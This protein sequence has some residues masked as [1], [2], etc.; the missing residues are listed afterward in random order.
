MKVLTKNRL[1][2]IYAL[3]LFVVIQILYSVGIL[4]NYYM[5]IIDIALIN[6]ILATSLNIINGFTG[7][8]SLG[9]GGFMAVGAYTAGVLTTLIWKVGQMQALPK[10]SLFIIAVLLGGVVAAIIGILLGIPSLR[11]RGDYLAIVT[12]AFQEIVRVGINAIDY[13][14]GP[15]GLLGIPRLSTF[16]MIYFFTLISIFIMKNIVY[17]T[18][19]RAMKSIREDEVASELVG[20][21]TT[22][23]KV[24]AFS[25]G[26][27]FAGVAGALLVHV[28][29][30]AHP[31]MFGFT[32][33]SIAG[34][35]SILVMVYIGGAG[36][37]SGSIIAAVVLT[38]L[39]ELLRLGIDSLNGL[40]IFPFTIG[41]EWR[42]VVYAVLLIVVML[43]RTEGIMGQREFKILVPEEEEKNATGSA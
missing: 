36:S 2:F 13:V 37:L 32:S 6:I 39:S 23:Y 30:L 3:I 7:Q 18:V 33:P 42:M 16:A 35:L 20:V 14:G 17:S 27:F 34:P 11:L 22:K 26:A 4:N 21:N 1:L 10:F 24:M 5:Q 25:I 29:Q 9:H 43:Y 12:L 40:H 8:F 19:G 38:V 28:L 41:P 15:R 31:T